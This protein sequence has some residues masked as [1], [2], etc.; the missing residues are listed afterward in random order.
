MTRRTI[1]WLYS[2]LPEL[3]RTGV[4]DGSTAQRIERHY[5]PIPESNARTLLIPIFGVLGALL[6][7]A[8]VMLLFGHNWEE[9]GRPLRAALSFSLLLLGQAL[10]GWTLWGCSWGSPSAARSR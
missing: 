7:G 6:I 3:V 2:E 4:M 9:L 1:R 10:A 5:G 8:G